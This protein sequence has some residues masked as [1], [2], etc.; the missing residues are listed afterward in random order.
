MLLKNRF[1]KIILIINSIY[2]ISTT[3]IK[4]RKEHNERTKKQEGDL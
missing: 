4:K 1:T 3:K 2:F